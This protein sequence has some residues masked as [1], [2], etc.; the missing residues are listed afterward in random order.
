MNEFC[1]AGSRADG[2]P[3]FQLKC[4]EIWNAIKRAAA[5]PADENAREKSIEMAFSSESIIAQCDND[6]SALDEDM[7]CPITKQFRFDPVKCI[8]R[9]DDGDTRAYERSALEGHFQVQLSQ[10]LQ[11]REP[12]NTIVTVTCPTTCRRLRTIFQD[13]EHKL[14]MVR[15]EAMLKRIE[16]LRRRQKKHA[17]RWKSRVRR[18]NASFSG[19]WDTMALQSWPTSSKTSSWSTALTKIQPSTLQTS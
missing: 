12:V 14:V 11:N 16:G 5:A 15:D 9:D 13:G 1:A 4:A 3:E 6:P 8:F 7:L 2:N 19:A 18:S 17:G 10:Q